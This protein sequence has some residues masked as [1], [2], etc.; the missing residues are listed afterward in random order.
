M[1]AAGLRKP[2]ARDTSKE[3]VEKMMTKTLSSDVPHYVFV[4]P[5]GLEK[6][7]L[8]GLRLNPDT[9]VG[10]SVKDKDGDQYMNVY[11]CGLDAKPIID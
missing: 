2:Q 11:Y 10:V 1:M 3:K 9:A 5:G 4:Q 6:F 7:V 8:A